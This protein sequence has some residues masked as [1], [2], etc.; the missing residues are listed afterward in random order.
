MVT[1]EHLN[2]F[3]HFSRGSQFLSLNVLSETV[4]VNYTMMVAVNCDSQREPIGI[5][6][7]LVVLSS[8]FMVKDAAAHAVGCFGWL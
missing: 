6:A 4:D 1:S 3:P 7:L 5:S 8:A 2:I